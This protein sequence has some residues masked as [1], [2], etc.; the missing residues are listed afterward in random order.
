MKSMVKIGFIGLGRRG[1]SVLR[2]NFIDMKDVE[3]VAI[4]DQSVARMEEACNFI[5]EKGRPTPMMTTNYRDIIQHP[6]IDAVIIMIGWKNRPRIAMESMRAGKYTAIEVGCADTLQECYDL[7]STYEETGIPVMML[8]NCCYGR[9]E[10]MVLNMVKQGLFGEIVHCTGGYHHYLNEVELFLN[11]DKDEIPHYRLAEYRDKNCDNYPTHELGPISKVLSINRGNRFVS[12][13]SF[14]SKHIGIQ[15]FAKRH[16]GEDSKYAKIDYQ[17]SDIVNTHLRCANGETVMITLDTTLPRAYYSRNFSVRGTKGMSS[18]ERRVVYCEGMQEE[19]ENNETEMFERYDHPLH[20]EYAA[21]GVKEGHGGMD[22]LVCR[23]F[24]EAVKNGT[25]TPIDA[26][27]TATWLAIGVLS[28]QSIQ[29]G[30]VTVE[31]PDFTNGKWQNRE[32]F[33]NSKYCLDAIIENDP[34]PLF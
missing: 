22:W 10:M 32:P 6:S 17:Q 18:E 27:D 8:E 24:I 29:G 5:C 14:G 34:T 20:R 28:A 33:V 11:I 21:Q 1:I 4:C 31:F 2:Q 7:V 30:S 16:F 12:L 19:I 25:N 15:D 9:R 26:Y 3:I 13:T 23:A